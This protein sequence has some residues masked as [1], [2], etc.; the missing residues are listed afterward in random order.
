VFRD[1]I[2]PRANVAEKAGRMLVGNEIDVIDELRIELE[3]L[4]IKVDAIGKKLDDLKIELN[5]KTKL[6]EQG[7]FALVCDE[8]V[9]TAPTIEQST[10][11]LNVGDVQHRRR[12]RRARRRR[13]YIKLGP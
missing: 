10:K 9:M 6:W 5:E 2:L 1:Y 3:A 11:S 7:E 13:A 8:L 12:R 4:L